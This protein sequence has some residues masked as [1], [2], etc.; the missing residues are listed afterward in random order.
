MLLLIKLSC[1]NNIIYKLIAALPALRA[2]KMEKVNEIQKEINSLEARKYAIENSIRNG[3]EIKLVEEIL[4]LLDGIGIREGDYYAQTRLYSNIEGV[5]NIRK[6]GCE[7]IMVKTL[8]PI[9]ELL[10]N[11][12]KIQGKKYGIVICRSRN[13]EESL[14]Y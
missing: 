6:Y 13:F 1:R 10:P 4:N 9:G 8:S 11:E 5:K 2:L 12:I 7:A 14:N 3:N